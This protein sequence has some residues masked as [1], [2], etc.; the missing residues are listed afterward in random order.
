MKI[1]KKKARDPSLIMRRKWLTLEEKLNIIKSHEE[2]KTYAKIAREN[3][4]N[5]SSIRTIIRKKEQYKEQAVWKT[6]SFSKMATR[7][8]STLLSIMERLLIAWIEDCNLKRI[9]LTENAIQ[10]KALS[11]FNELK[12]KEGGETKEKFAASRGWFYRFK[13]RINLQNCIISLEKPMDREAAEKFCSEFQDIIQDGSYTHQQIFNVDETI[14]YWKKLPS[15]SFIAETEKSQQGYRASKDGL[16]LLL[17]GNASGDMKLQPL[18]V[19]RSE[20]PS[21]LKDTEKTSLP[22]IWRS[23]KKA[24]LTQEVFSDWFHNHFCP[25]VEAYCRAQG[26]EY[27]ILLLLDSAPNHDIAFCND[28]VKIVFLP[29]YTAAL[30]QPLSQGIF[31]TFKGC[32]LRQIL[33]QAI[34][35][36][37]G[38]ESVSLLDFWRNYNIKNAINNISAS[39]NEISSADMVS[40]WHRLVPGI[41]YKDFETQMEIVAQD[42]ITMGRYFGLKSMDIPNIRNCIDTTFNESEEQNHEIE[43]TFICKEEPPDIEDEDTETPSEDLVEEDLEKIIEGVDT[44]CERIVA[45]ETD[46]ERSIK[47]RQILQNGIQY[48]RDLFEERKKKRGSYIT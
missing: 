25:S 22:V 42:I 20:T 28:N 36:S 1:E 4:M 11:L 39:W 18:V 19:F 46:M 13:N 14:L 8:R 40:V 24:W 37:T 30:V 47:V 38:V 41:N 29:A 35:S 34:E 3:G 31:A 44:A 16:T 5:E 7:Q 21:A 27:K 2:G 9:Q 17:G 33:S 45:C 32:Y 10:G 26:I 15:E 6:S 43:Q 12:E 23:N 48:Y